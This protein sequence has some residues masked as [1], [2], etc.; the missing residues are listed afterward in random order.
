MT[1]E[2]EHAVRQQAR[3][4]ANHDDDLGRPRTKERAEWWVGELSYK[5]GIVDSRGLIDIDGEVARAFIRA[6]RRVPREVWPTPDTSGT[7]ETR[8]ATEMAS[9][10]KGRGGSSGGGNPRNG[11]ATSEEQHED[12]MRV[13]RKE[14]YDGVRGIAQSVAERVKEG[15]DENDVI[16]EEVDGSY[17]VI[18]THA[19]F[20]VLMCSDHRDAYSEDYGQAPVEGDTIN[21][22]AL[23][24]AAMARDV[25]EQ[26]AAGGTVDE[27]RRPTRYSRERHVPHA[28]RGR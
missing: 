18:Y 22:A 23:A 8:K 17:W 27:T 12:A 16:H 9:R 25:A 10:R 21:W 26:V 7:S 13:L 5:L 19:N 6:Y 14:Y 28:R 15:E 20:Q 11:G 1:R 3:Q 4:A 24:Y 2:Q